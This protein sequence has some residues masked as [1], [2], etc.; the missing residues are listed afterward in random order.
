MAAEAVAPP[1]QRKRK[2]E[3]FEVEAII[4]M[5]NVVVR[6]SLPPHSLSADH[7]L[8]GT[9]GV[10]REMARLSRHRNQLGD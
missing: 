8:I 5:R 9:K 3:V 4:G 10:S 7:G 1:P 2:A 6:P